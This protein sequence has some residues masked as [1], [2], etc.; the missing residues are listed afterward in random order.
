MFECARIH[1][2]AQI[3]GDIFYDSNNDGSDEDEDDDDTFHDTIQ[4]ESAIYDTDDDT[5]LSGDDP[6]PV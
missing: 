1:G 5:I 2:M 6:E 3:D 4:V